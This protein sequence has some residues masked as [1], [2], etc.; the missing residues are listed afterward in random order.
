MSDI[1]TSNSRGTDRWFLATAPIARA[2][3][4]L[5][6][7]MAAAMLVGALYNVIN[8]GFIGSQHDATLL[9]AVTL[10]SPVLAIVLAVGGV[11]G[12]GASALVGRL[13]GASENDPAAAGQIKHVASFAVWGSAIAG[14][15]IAVIGLVFLHP[16]VIVLGA[17]AA[18]IPATSA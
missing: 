9:A 2:L 18:A 4:H 1:D 6:V 12:V 14:A 10:G 7:P 11:F 5:C 15:V 8:A 13:L 3:V 16:L 17:N